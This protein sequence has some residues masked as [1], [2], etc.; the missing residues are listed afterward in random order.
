MSTW[1]T[2][3]I[4]NGV[5]GFSVLSETGMFSTR[6]IARKGVSRIKG[7]PAGIENAKKHS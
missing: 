6:P 5:S 3:V 2:I 7:L 1:I 4:M